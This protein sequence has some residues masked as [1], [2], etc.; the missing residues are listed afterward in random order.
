MV[1]PPSAI[2]SAATDHGKLT[3]VADKRQSLL[4]AGDDNEMFMTRSLNVTL[5][6]TQQHLIV[7]SG[8]SEAY[9]NKR[10]LEVNI[11]C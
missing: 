11:R 2:H 9:N 6:T 1:R 4:M 8:K 3:L 5:T 7:C 10:L